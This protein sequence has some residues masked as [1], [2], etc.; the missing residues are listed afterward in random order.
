MTDDF[1]GWARHVVQLRSP[2]LGGDRFFYF[3][4]PPLPLSLHSL[5]F[6]V[7][8]L[9]VVGEGESGAA[10]QNRD[11]IGK[12]VLGWINDGVIITNGWVLS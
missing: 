5:F 3:L 8:F 11:Q 10:F 12:G 2:P 1:Q 6:W 9:E 7:F 4:S